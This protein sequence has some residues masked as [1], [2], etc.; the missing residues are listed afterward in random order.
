MKKLLLVV[1]IVIA[2]KAGAYLAADLVMGLKLRSET[3]AMKAAGYAVTIAEIK[4]HATPEGREAGRLIMAAYDTTLAHADT[5][6]KRS[7]ELSN[8]G[9][10]DSL[11]YADD[12]VLFQ[13]LLARYSGSI[14][15]LLK[16]AEYP[17]VNFPFDYDKGWAMSLDNIPLA[18]QTGGRLMRIYA[19]ACFAQG[20]PDEGIRVLRAS[21]H[22]AAGIKDNFALMMLVR[23]LQLRAAFALVRKFA[24][25]LR[26]EALVALQSEVLAADV[27]ASFRAM[28]ETEMV[29]LQQAIATN[30]GW[31][32]TELSPGNPIPRFLLAVPPVRKYARRLN[33]V[34]TR[35]QIEHAA[36]PWYESKAGWDRDSTRLQAPTRGGLLGQALTINA[37]LFFIRAEQG[38]A[39][40][41]I[42]QLG[43]EI[44]RY[45]AEHGR[46][47]ENLEA[48]AGRT[49][50]DP[51][52]GQPY[53]YQ[54]GARGF[55]LYSVGSDMRDDGGVRPRDLSWQVGT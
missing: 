50:I 53:L 6:N 43:L 38:R 17:Q 4:P 48:A 49:L 29:L 54:P 44:L 37:R 35:L 16:A 33:M 31:P 39:E 24:P 11:D 8:V 13:Q 22:L 7:R 3:Q 28:L 46:L 20:R 26:P 10:G 18:V 14:T 45:R 25:G 51:F 15:Q 34:T 32:Q 52:S 19:K 2:V 55:L 40:N 47:P 42:T 27:K 36:R 9:L 30:N 21:I 1:I 5:V 23:D 41:E 12:P